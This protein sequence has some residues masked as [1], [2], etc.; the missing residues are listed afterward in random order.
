MNINNTPSEIPSQRNETSTQIQHTSNS[1]IFTDQN[2]NENLLNSE[3]PNNDN[4]LNNNSNSVANAVKKPMEINH[5]NKEQGIILNAIEG[6]QIHE[7][8]YA[9]GS[10][11]K[12]K[13]II[14]ASRLSNQRICLYLAGKNI[15]DE[16][17]QQ[18]DS[19][20]INDHAIKVRRLITPSKKIVIS[21]VC[22]SIPN[23]ILEKELTKIG[24]KLNS[25]IYFIRMGLSN[26]EYSHII[27]FRRFT[28]ITP[29][30]R[31]PIPETALITFQGDEYRIF[32][33]DDQV[34]CYRCN[35]LG[36]TAQ[37]C[38]YALE[39][40][41]TI[42]IQTDNNTQQQASQSNVQNPETE[43]TNTTQQHK[44]TKTKEK[45]VP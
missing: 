27:S 29:N 37:K 31:D 42:E 3:T 9:V 17:L 32:I 36:H 38:N 18:V 4:N 33:Q 7:Y 12:P 23:A 26:P 8:I 24:L 44:D 30:E 11:V 22:P 5:P 43:Q 15:V 2:E 39:N 19:I 16:L 34:K 40:I 10:I 45:N 41:E 13:N 35:R 6:L 14:A 20:K 28:Y 21:N 25:P 1:T